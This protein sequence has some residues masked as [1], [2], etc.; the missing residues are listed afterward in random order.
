MFLIL[1]KHMRDMLMVLWS[2]EQ[3]LGRIKK[4]PVAQCNEQENVV[5]VHLV[6]NLMLLF[7]TCTCTRGVAHCRGPRLAPGLLRA[8]GIKQD[9]APC[10]HVQTPTDCVLYAYYVCFC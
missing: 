8:P 5:N 1:I 6:T 7:S 2:W 3:H 4:W 10:A 9:R